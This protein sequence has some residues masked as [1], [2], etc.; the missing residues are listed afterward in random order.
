MSLEDMVIVT[1]MVARGEVIRGINSDRIGTF[2][3]L[4]ALTWT[5]G[6]AAGF[7]GASLALGLAWGVGTFVASSAL[8][9]VIYRS[10]WTRARVMALMHVI[11]RR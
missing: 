9:A 2:F 7:S 8:L 4:L 5:A 11:T 1:D 6:T 3:F 10:A